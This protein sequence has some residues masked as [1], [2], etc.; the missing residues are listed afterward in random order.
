[1]R[2]FVDTARLTR[3][4]YAVPFASNHCFLHKETRRFNSTVVSPL[5]VQRYFDRHKPRGS[6]C[7]VMA[8]GDSWSDAIGFRLQEQD[9]F[10]NREKHLAEYAA[11]VAPMLEKTY[12]N[13]ARVRRSEERRVGKECRSRW[14]PYH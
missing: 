12:A 3:A 1:M 14:S 5:D 10:T 2:E 8:P 7:V 9:F 6:E 4:R 11:D 13:E